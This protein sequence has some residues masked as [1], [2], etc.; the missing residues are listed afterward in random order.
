[1]KRIIAL[2]ALAS[3]LAGQNAKTTG[4]GYRAAEAVATSA[5]VL[6]L[7]NGEQIQLHNGDRLSIGETYILIIDAYNDNELIDYSDIEV[8]ELEH[9]K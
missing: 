4:D 3:F 2:L 1:M 9:M 6:T 7:E 5:D 8:Y